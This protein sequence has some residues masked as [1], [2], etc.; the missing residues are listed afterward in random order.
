MKTINETTK[1]STHDL[2]NSLNVLILIDRSVPREDIIEQLGISV[3]KAHQIM[4]DDIAFFKAS[5]RLVSPEQ[6]NGS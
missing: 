1:P 5:C 4:R 6:C 3:G 2:V